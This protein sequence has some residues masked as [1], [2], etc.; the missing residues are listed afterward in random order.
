MFRR[1]WGLTFLFWACSIFNI[2]KFSWWL[3]LLSAI[4]YILWI[5]LEKFW[6]SFLWPQF[7]MQHGTTASHCWMCPQWSKHSRCY[8]HCTSLTVAIGHNNRCVINAIHKSKLSIDRRTLVVANNIEKWRLSRKRME[9]TG[10]VALSENWGEIT[11][12]PLIPID[13]HQFPY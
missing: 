4:V 3:F 6:S 12:N 13:Y 2:F 5:F 10:F 1:G 7:S 8:G 9:R 11:G